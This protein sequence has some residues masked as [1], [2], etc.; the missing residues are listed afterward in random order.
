[1]KIGDKVRFLNDVG[2]GIVSGF[3][4]KNL[5]LVKDEDGFEIPTPVDEVIVVESNDYN[6]NLGVHNDESGRG[7]SNPVS[8][9]PADAPVTYRP[10]ERKEGDILN[11]FL[12]FVPKNI[13]QI[14][15]TEFEAYLV[16]DSNYSM[17]YTVM[18]REGNTYSLRDSGQ[19]EPNTK[20]YVGDFGHAELNNLEHLAVQLIAFKDDKAFKL[21][22]AISAEIKVDTVKFFKLHCFKEN[23]FFETPAL[24]YDI[25]RDDEAGKTEEKLDAKKLKE[26][27]LE[28]KRADVSPARKAKPQKKNNE[29]IE[30]DLHA[31]EVLESTAGLEPADILE[32]QLEIFRR[33]MNENKRHKGRKIV[34]IH[35]KG[36]GVLRNEVLKVLRKEYKG[37]TSQDASFREYGFGATLI[38]IG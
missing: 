6:L 7:T 24:V 1:M 34:I 26:A 14:S 29:I 3:K 33:A 10:M 30:I 23:P 9:D 38:K 8:D 35:G 5:V 16:N 13:R 2:G 21:K 20:L 11:A 32:Y 17:Y 4:E 18:S 15:S 19:M 25:V 36:N 31:D 22:P 37:C 27:L 28:T 12:A